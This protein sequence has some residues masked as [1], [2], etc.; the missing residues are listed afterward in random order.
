M[1]GR[2]F[3]LLLEHDAIAPADEEFG[4]R[5][6]IMPEARWSPRMRRAAWK[7][8]A[9]YQATLEDLGIDYRAIPEPP[10]GDDSA[11]RKTGRFIRYEPRERIFELD[12]PRI[13]AINDIVRRI[14]GRRFV[15]EKRVWAV[16]RD[17][18]V[19][20]T[21]AQLIDEHGFE[22][23][24]FTVRLVGE[25][26]AAIAR[27]RRMIELSHAT[28][29]ELTIE[30]GGELYPFQNGGIEYGLAA[31]RWMCGDQVGLGKTM[32][33]LGFLAAIEQIARVAA[34]PALIVVP[35]PVKI[36]WYRQTRKW[37]PT[38]SVQFLDARPPIAYGADIT[39]VNFDILGRHAKLQEIRWNTIIVDESH[40]LKNPKTQRYQ[41]VEAIIAKAQ[42]RWRVLLSGTAIVNRVQELATQ[43]TL[44][45]QW[46]AVGG[47]AHF[48]RAYASSS[49]TPEAIEQL[50]RRMRASFYV[51]RERKDV[52]PNLRPP[53][54]VLIP[55]E[56]TNRDEYAAA[57]RDVAGWYAAHAI[58]E[59]SFIESIAHLPEAEQNAA[60]AR[61]K[62]D[63]EWRAFMAEALIRYTVLKRIAARGKMQA[64]RKW[65]ADMLEAG[66][67]LI[68]FA[69]HQD[70][71][72]EI[73]AAFKA[74]FIHGDVPLAQRQRIVDDFARGRI[75][76]LAMNIQTGG[77][78]IDGLQ[79]GAN[80]VAFLELGWTPGEHDQAEG[81][82]DRSGQ[83]HTVGSAF[84]I[85]EDTIEEDNWQMIDD[86]RG[87]VSRANEGKASDYAIERLNAV[88]EIG[89]RM[90]E[91]LARAG[92]EPAPRPAAPAPHPEPAPAYD[93]AMAGIEQIALL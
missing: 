86:K 35:A 32:Q 46:K 93:P 57:E 26:R 45:D 52:D 69:H 80:N 25:H 74:P 23:D 67:H 75:P 55:I 36:N 41:L 89:R 73:A 9:R 53:D 77:T 14:P 22:A 84:L 27:A 85:A 4:R 64:A 40:K 88:E 78:G 30:M 48:N 66:E 60:I 5:L 59:R 63:A 33:G 92:A 24:T 43:I 56:I 7:I 58:K 39:I 51:R 62:T 13:N 38:K 90:L 91:R 61:H 29:S 17:E 34:T 70:I 31:E 49:A 76:F 50:N 65:V 81:R 68:A 10:T 8:L 21:I 16:P 15:G 12:Y 18:A 37:L 83:Q 71:V 2:A 6:A 47:R 72:E 28:T 11:P 79:H 82:V 87:T 20:E 19:Y 44:L 1:I 54:R 3:R 42:P